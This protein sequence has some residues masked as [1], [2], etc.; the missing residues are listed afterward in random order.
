MPCTNTV[1][2]RLSKRYDNDKD[3]LVENLSEVRSVSFTTD[4][5][6]SSATER[7]ITI[8]A[9]RIA[10]QCE[11]ESNVLMTRAMP[12]RH[13]DV[14]LANK[15]KNCASEFGIKTKMESVV[16]DNAGNMECASNLCE[17]WRDAGCFVIH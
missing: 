9:L 1:K 7:Y 16:H 13:T 2:S 12:E 4:T 10:D 17:E 3:R 6:I 15:L 14:N 8:T 11:M 5:C